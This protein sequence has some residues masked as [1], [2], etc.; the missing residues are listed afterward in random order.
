[1]GAEPLRGRRCPGGILCRQ[2]VDTTPTGRDLEPDPL[3]PATV[4]EI[5][6]LVGLAGDAHP[7]SDRTAEQRERCLERQEPALGDLSRLDDH[8]VQDGVVED[9]AVEEETHATRT[10]RPGVQ[11]VNADEPAG[12]DVE[13][14]LFSGFAATSLPWR[15][16]DLD[17]TARNRPAAL[18]RRLQDQQSAMA[19]TYQRTCGRGNGRDDRQPGGSP[20]SP[21]RMG[22]C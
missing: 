11:E 2:P 8:R 6:H 13:A 17:D 4:F 14:A 7:T 21:W 12:S 1:M 3:H 16:T 9:T 10:A 15:L 19:A 22:S 5:A 18:V 20:A